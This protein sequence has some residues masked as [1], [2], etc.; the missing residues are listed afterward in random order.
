MHPSAE[1]PKGDS[2]SQLWSWIVQYDVPSD[3]SDTEWKWGGSK[4][5][6]ATTEDEAR[7]AALAESE[8]LKIEGNKPFTAII[9]NRSK[10]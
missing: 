8:A 5:G 6:W 9:V 4:I 2:M 1:I 3:R 7:A 10:K